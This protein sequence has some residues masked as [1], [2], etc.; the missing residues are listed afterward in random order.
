MT[1]G[2]TWANVELGA[3]Q[4]NKNGNR[5]LK[6]AGWNRRDLVASITM[7]IG[8]QEVIGMQGTVRGN[9][10][11]L[12]VPLRRIQDPQDWEPLT[13]GIDLSDLLAQQGATHGDIKTLGRWSSKTYEAYIRKGRANNWK[14]AQAQLMKATKRSP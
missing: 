4:A 9:L 5:A 6:M 8:K 1:C 14:G 12:T 2:T 11:E 3:G 7:R 10:G 13:D